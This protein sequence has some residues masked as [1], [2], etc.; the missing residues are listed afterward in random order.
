MFAESLHEA[1]AKIN[2]LNQAH[3]ERLHKTSPTAP[4]AREQTVDAVHADN[5][6]LRPLPGQPECPDVATSAMT[7]VTASDGLRPEHQLSDSTA[8]RRHILAEER[9]SKQ[10][11]V[12]YY[13][14]VLAAMH[15]LR[16]EITSKHSQVERL[17][18]ELQPPPM[19]Q[20]TEINDLSGKR[21]LALRIPHILQCSS[22]WPQHPMSFPTAALREEVGALAKLAIPIVVTASIDYFGILLTIIFAGHIL[23][24]D[25]FDAVCLGTTITN[26]SGYSMIIAMASPMDSLCS[27]AKGARHWK[28]FS[29][30][31]HRAILCTAI[32]L[33]PIV[34]LWVFAGDLLALCGFNAVI[35]GDVALWTRIYIAMLPAYATRTIAMRFLCSQGIFQPLLP[36]SILVHCLWHPL[37]LYVVFV[38]LD[39]DQFIL[40]P[41][42][43]IVSC[44][45]QNALLLGYIVVR[46]PHHEEAF[47]RVSC[48]EIL[49][50]ETNW[51]DEEDGDG[52][53]NPD[54]VDQGLS[55]YIQLL[56][57]G[58]FSICGEWWAWELMT[59]IV[60]LL[61]ATQLAVDVIYSTIIPMYF[62]LPLGLGMAGA[63]R[64][65]TLIGE[66]RYPIAKS[67]GN[68]LLAFSL[69]MAA[70]LAALS[71]ALR[72]YIPMIFTSDQ[73]VI[74]V[75]VSLSPLFCA[76]IVPH[77]LLGTFQGILRGIK[78]QADS[79]YAVLI[80]PWLTSIPLACFLAF[81]PSINLELWGMWAGNNVGY[82]VMNAL[83]LYFWL[84]FEWEAGDDPEREPLL[85]DDEQTATEAADVDA[86]DA[87][88]PMNLRWTSESFLWTMDEFEME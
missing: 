12:D 70:V 4:T 62:M 72:D 37:L 81:Y 33:T 40:F 53:I 68:A 54:V 87:T 41:L 59:I 5:K 50:W 30:T 86:V 52:R 18:Q 16:A 47:Q 73:R 71:Y 77:Q 88:D 84:S 1:I 36:I 27:Q 32:L 48:H 17:E 79:A 35:A 56:F 83:F 76:F 74:S 85:E 58:I 49:R 22:L 6:A 28:L 67:L 31:V 24:T 80:G 46:R 64:I 43:Q 57:A 66:N 63:A 65:G 14:A 20:N 82:Y 44:Y 7:A 61:G 9:Q 55:E 10:M 39:Y 15:A 23:S 60:G 38:A 8:I 78:R 21:K 11:A 45:L 3:R 25:G 69:L 34:V 51:E 19:R 2:A 42:C 26:I 75:A 29:L 13:N